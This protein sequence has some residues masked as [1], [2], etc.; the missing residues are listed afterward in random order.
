MFVP[1]TSGAPHVQLLGLGRQRHNQADPEHGLQNLVAA[2]G[3]ASGRVDRTRSAIVDR[4]RRSPRRVAHEGAQHVNEHIAVD[5]RHLHVR[6]RAEKPRHRETAMVMTD[7]RMVHATEE[8][9]HDLIYDV[10]AKLLVVALQLEHE[11]RK[12]RQLTLLALPHGTEDLL[13]Y[14]LRVLLPVDSAE[15]VCHLRDG[16]GVQQRVDLVSDKLVHGAPNLALHLGLYAV[17]RGFGLRNELFVPAVEILRVLEL[18][19]DV[20][21]VDHAFAGVRPAVQVV[22]WR[23]G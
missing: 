6:Q 3:V 8:L 14:V 10:D 22:S 18:G 15:V 17:H 16:A 4:A 13:P 9:F 5:A 11:S 21:H 1:A 20:H 7:F 2:H 19:H 12:G 23:R